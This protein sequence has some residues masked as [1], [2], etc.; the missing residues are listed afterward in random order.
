MNPCHGFKIFIVGA[1]FALFGLICSLGNLIF[2]PIALLGLYK[3]K[4]IRNFCRDLVRLAW[5]FFIFSTQICGYQRTKFSFAG[6][7]GSASQI[8]IANHPSLLDVVFLVSLVRRANC[9]VKASLGKNIFL[10][11]AIKACGYIPNTAN[12]ELLQK[13]I[14]AL[15]SG[16][17]LIIF[18]EG[19]RTAGEIVFHK[20]AAYI[21]VNSAKQLVAIGIKMDPP[22]LKKHEPW[23]KTPSVMIKYE[24][25][26]LFRLNLDGFC[27]DRP[28]PI[29]AREL[30]AFISENYTKEFKR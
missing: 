12:E 16:E 9:V 23:Y 6:E 1:N 18:P 7:L 30:H 5:S 14:D 22:S 2:I 10:A 20:A 26:E 21:A 3:F 4:F 25:K 28:N 27:A 17:S 19:T 24:F 11:P 15:K 8:I 13:S 29:R